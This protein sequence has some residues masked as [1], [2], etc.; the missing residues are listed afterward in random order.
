MR[1]LLTLWEAGMGS[2]DTNTFVIIFVSALVV[3]GFA[4][5]LRF[6]S[7]TKKGR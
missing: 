6:R 5:W 3:M 7:E 2:L 4:V 1:P